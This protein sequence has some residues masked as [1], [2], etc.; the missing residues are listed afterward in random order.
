MDITLDVQ[1]LTIGDI[2]DLEELCGVAFEKIDWKNPG[3]KLMKAI[4]FIA[5]RRENPDFTIEDARNVK[6]G[7]IKV[8]EENPTEDGDAS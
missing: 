3:G 2:E 5:G 1:E 4:V 8:N 7:E 6:L